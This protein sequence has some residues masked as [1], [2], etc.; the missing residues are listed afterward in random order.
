MKKNLSI[1]VLAYNEETS[2]RDVVL[3]LLPVLKILV[4]KYEILIID[5]GSKDNT[6]KIADNLAK[7]YEGIRVIHHKKNKGYGAGQKTG[8]RNA[9]YELVMAI[10]SDKQFDVGDIKKYLA[11]I[12]SFDV[13]VG[14][15][16]KRKD[17]LARRIMSTGFNFIVS[18]MFDVR[19]KDISWVKM[20]RKKALE[21]INVK[22]DSITADP[23]LIIK[24]H[25]KKNIK[26]KSIPVNYL[27]R[28]SG[29]GE[30]TDPK[31]ILI[32]LIDIFKL[33]YELNFRKC[34]SK[35]G[36]LINSG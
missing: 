12:T 8:F 29:K 13:V 35:E 28:E 4:D 7:K 26:I 30:S 11:M 25:K 23:E 1:I 34:S 17:S 10:P 33:W 24:L 31:T 21:G 20:I 18:T 15:R 27:Q 19:I 32:T 9:K 2:L 6:G 3:S 14:V 5:D 22:S 16:T 36:N